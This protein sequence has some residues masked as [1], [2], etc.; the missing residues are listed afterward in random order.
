MPRVP[1]EDNER[2]SLRPASPAEAELLPEVAPCNT[3]PVNFT[4]QSA[5]HEADAIIAEA[6]V[7]EASERDYARIVELLEN[8]PRPNEKLLA[9]AGAMPTAPMHAAANSHRGGQLT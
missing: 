2:M 3:D 4:T 7:I 5:L 8:P 9:A 6:E 1:V